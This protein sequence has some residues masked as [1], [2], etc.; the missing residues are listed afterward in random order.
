MEAIEVVR[1]WVGVATA[2]VVDALGLATR[3]EVV[4]L[5][6]RV[7]EL[8]AMVRGPVDD[9]L[10]ARRATVPPRMRDSIARAGA[11]LGGVT[12]A[13]RRSKAAGPESAD[14]ATPPPE[15]R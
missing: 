6:R 1:S 9:E 12:V 10:P 3:E 7:D 8:H 4:A 14:A 5:R 11:A 2:W 15:G 13:S